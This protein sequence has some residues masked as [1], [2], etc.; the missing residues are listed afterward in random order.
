MS[1][2]LIIGNNFSDDRGLLT[3]NNYLDL[4]N[5]KRI[6][7]IENYSIDFIREWQGHRIEQRWFSVVNGTFIIKIIEI[8]DW[9][10]PNPNLSK[11]SF[12]LNSINFNIL[13]IPAGYVTSIQALSEKSKLMVMSDYAYGE[14][15]DE[16]RFSSDC[17][18]I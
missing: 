12:I 8:D 15:Q 10:N 11:K 5:I 6:Y 17:F 18:Y 2:E 13:F 9:D 3:Y 16:Y 7:F 1:P 14:I 4:I